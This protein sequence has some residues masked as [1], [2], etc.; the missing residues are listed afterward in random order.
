MMKNTFKSKYPLRVEDMTSVFRVQYRLSGPE[1]YEVYKSRVNSELSSLLHAT[2]LLQRL[3][4][5]SLSVMLGVSLRTAQRLT[6]SLNLPD[7]FTSYLYILQTD[8][9]TLSNRTKGENPC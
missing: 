1:S 3:N 8:E 4:P 9:S 5:Y 2:A 6:S 7:L